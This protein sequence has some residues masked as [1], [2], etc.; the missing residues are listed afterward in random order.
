MTK[1]DIEIITFVYA[2]GTMD[3]EVIKKEIPAAQD[4]SS[5]DIN[6]LIQ[7]DWERLNREVDYGTR[8]NEENEIL[9][10]KNCSV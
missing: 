10:N 4:M 2:Y 7:E 6:N 8:P 1:E 3:P 9:A 5:K